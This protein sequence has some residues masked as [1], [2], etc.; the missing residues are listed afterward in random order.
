MPIRIALAAAVLFLATA[1]GSGGSTSGLDD[2]TTTTGPVGGV[3]LTDKDFE[4]LTGQTEVEVLARDNTFVPAYIEISPGTTV[5]FRNI[6]RTEHNVIPVEDGA[7][8][9]IEAS[10][11]APKDAVEMTFDR[12]GTYP[13]PYYCSLHGSTTKGMVGGVRVVAD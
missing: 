4:D 8:E 6:G 12:E 1:C 9:P 13:Y 10:R 11:F 5:S 2:S 7:F 3:D